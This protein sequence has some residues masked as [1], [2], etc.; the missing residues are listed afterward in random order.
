MNGDKHG[1]CNVAN[2]RTLC[3][4]L[5]PFNLVHNPATPMAMNLILISMAFW[6]FRV[7]LY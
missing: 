2:K 4:V 5:R 3:A 6:V 1:I 7:T